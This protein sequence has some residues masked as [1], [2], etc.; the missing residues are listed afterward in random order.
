MI[1]WINDLSLTQHDREIADSIA[2]L[3]KQVIE[4]K[5]WGREITDHFDGSP[6]REKI[7]NKQQVWLAEMARVGLDVRDYPPDTE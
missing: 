4:W 5:R 6:G 2:R 7:Q 3:I 1:E